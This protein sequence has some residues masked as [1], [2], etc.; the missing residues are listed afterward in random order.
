MENRRQFNNGQSNWIQIDSH[1]LE[2]ITELKEKYQLTEEILSYAL[3]KHEQGRVEY[4]NDEGTFLVVFNAPFRKKMDNHYL[5]QPV[6]FII[7]EKNIFS[8][9]RQETQYVVPLIEGILHQHP[10]QS[11]FSLLF[12]SL[13]TITGSYFPI[14]EDITGQRIAL[15]DRL[16]NHT[17][18][19]NL[20]ALSD[21]S[22]GLVYLVTATKQNTTLLQSIKT[23]EV[24]HKMNENE[25]EELDDAI[26][27]ARQA[28]SMT[29]VAADIL[30]QLTSTYNNLLNNNLNDTMKLLTVWSLLLTI[31]TI[32]TG[33]FGMNMKLPFTDSAFSW[34]LVVI[35][36]IALSLWL[37]IILW[38]RIK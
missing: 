37:L 33:F 23:L 11:V 13:L 15:N 8:F 14:L 22:I 30:Q 9:T 24:F 32:V 18:N 17:T 34:G 31:P 25:K 29:Q 10:D 27:E 38:R 35:I 1:N 4:D 20:L 12:H 26:V 6:T 21:L 2:T 19:K 5:T 7:K 36:S 3:D 16:R 28:D